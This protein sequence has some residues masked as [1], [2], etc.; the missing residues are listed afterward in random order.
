MAPLSFDASTLEIW[1]ALLNGGRLAI[2]PAPMPTLDRN[3][4]RNQGRRDHAVADGGAV[5]LMVD[6]RIDGLRPLRQ[7]IAGGDVCR[8]LMSPRRWRRCRMPDRE[9]LWTDREH[10]IHVLLRGAGDSRACRVASHRD[11]DPGTTVYVLDDE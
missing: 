3:S 6:R 7:L 5:P 9:W 1:G 11:G 4:R 8:C 10:D 2:V